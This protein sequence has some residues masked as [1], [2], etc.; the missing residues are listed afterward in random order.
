MRETPAGRLVADFGAVVHACSR[1][2]ENVLY[3]SE[4]G[5][6]SLRRRI[7]AQLVDTDPARHRVWTQHPPE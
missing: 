1:F 6:I 7:T 4:P 2:D 5:N 3:L